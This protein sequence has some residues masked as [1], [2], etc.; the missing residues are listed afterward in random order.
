MICAS[1]DL[2]YWNKFGI[3]GTQFALGMQHGV[4]KQLQ[5]AVVYNRP[6]TILLAVNEQGFHCLAICQQQ[7]QLV[8]VPATEKRS[9]DDD[10][11]GLPEPSTSI[12]TGQSHLWDVTAPCV[13]HKKF[14]RNPC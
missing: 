14:E 1:F 11:Q 5:A 2:L 6:L 7:L 4:N 3:A 12:C 13:T 10:E 8:Q 9:N